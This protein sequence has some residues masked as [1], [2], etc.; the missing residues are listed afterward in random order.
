MEKF[1]SRDRRFLIAC[2]AIIVVGTALT[3]LLFK[4]AFPEA[5]IEFRVNRSQARLAGEK[6][7]ADLKRDIAGARFAGRFDVDEE[8]KVYLE[9]ELGLERASRFYG[10]D[11]KVW[12]W[13]MRW[14]RSGVKEEERVEITPRGDLA[15]F[16]SVRR[17]DAPG[18]RLTKEEARTRAL[19]FLEKIGIAAGTLKSIEISPVTRP[20]RTDWN[21][22]DEKRDFKMAEATVR[23]STT[24]S[25]AEV[26]GFRE[27]VHVPES[28]SRDYRRLRSKNLT[29]GTV[30]T[31]GLFLTFIAM[32][33]VLITKIV[34]RDVRWKLV[35]AFGAIAFVLALLS[36]LNAIPLTLY[37][38]DTSSPLSSH[39]TKELVLGLLAAVATGAGIAVIVAA[40][41]PVYRE[42]FREHL[43]LSGMFSRRGLRTKRFFLSVVLGYALTAF[44][45]AYQAVFYVVAARFGA[46]A[47]AETPYSD[48][49]NTALPWATVLL[50]GF[51]PAVSEEGISRMFS[52]SFLDRLGAGRVAAVVVPAII[53]GFGHAAYPNQPFYIRGAE[54]GLAGILMGL[55]MLRYGVLPLL[56]WHFTV[57]A[58]YTAFL[59]LRS[60][61]LYYVVSGAIA[62]GILLLPLTA[63]LVSYRKRGGFLSEEGLTNGDE[64]FVPAPP[65]PARAPEEVP[66][67]RRLPRRNLEIAAAAAVLFVTSF[68]LPA[69]RPDSLAEDR[70]GRAQA[71]A[72]ARRFLR[73]NGAAPERFHV[74][75]YIGTGFP[76]DEEVRRARPQDSGQI[77]AFSEPAARYVLARGGEPAFER[78]AKEYLPL[79]YWVVR[80]FE[81]EKKEEWKVLVDA[82]RSRVVAFVNPI[83]EAAP[84][85]PPPGVDDARS[86]AISAAAKLGYPARDYAAIDVGTQD[87]PKRTDTTVVLESARAAVVEAR[88]RLTAVFH[89]PRLA[90]FIP[91]IKVPESYLRDYSR[92]S[93]ADWVLLAAKIVAIGGFVGIGVI[94]FLRLVRGGA[95]RWR[96]V[97]G[98]LLVAFVGVALALANAIPSLDR[99]YST[100]TPYSLF[101]IGIAV[102]LTIGAIALVCAAGVG[103]VVLSGARPGW[104]A[105]L[106]RGGSLGD[107][108]ARAA[109]AAIG[110]AGLSHWIS[111]AASRFPA[112]FEIDPTLPRALE[113]WFPGYA[114]FWSAATATFSLA[115]VA[116][117]IALASRAPTAR[118]RPWRIL[119]LGA[120]LLA[121]VP[122]GA[123]SLGEFAAAF[124]PE[125][126]MAAW[127]GFVAFGLLKDHAA[128]WVL[129]GAFYLGGNR[130]AELLGQPAPP[131]RAAGW[132]V[133]VLV[134]LAAA[135][136]VAGR[137]EPRTLPGEIP[138]TELRELGA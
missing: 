137:R 11:A 56:V 85:A 106:K 59:L 48:L 100:E 14:F 101:Q 22:V 95:F 5:S 82:T 125:V 23:Y 33:G 130:A 68:F 87:R 72:I 51:L 4:R 6:F 26:T 49:L 124:V 86:R 7:L 112:L 62:S 93:A 116:A 89:G 119:F 67:V 133:V 115:V 110:T 15:G 102:S 71:E 120:L 77:P 13:R 80:F 30:A 92:R 103:F 121:L 126:V 24:V 40:A 38:Y 54:V 64:G 109:V 104:R 122:I 117:T 79:A 138:A 107:A 118:E 134:V 35:A 16:E 98:P 66:A 39:L 46:W 57:D 128:A 18:A 78:L 70:A 73:V 136:L 43:S 61:N 91:T 10:T 52:I 90:A 123:R 25:G 3:S 105:A 76:E 12:R 69:H 97:V 45:F 81:P 1:N 127:L 113:R 55:L 37:E 36:T 131:D 132:S 94:L 47:P 28:W 17:E 60:A 44:F 21:F 83:E 20:K 32:L 50:I 19:A 2:V 88:P 96:R 111:I 114:G 53:W 65:S 99:A 58:T 63:A 129:F 41:E 29:A 27:V 31:F 74:V 75:S 84:A 8:P 9:R 42:R 135:A 34:R 108:F